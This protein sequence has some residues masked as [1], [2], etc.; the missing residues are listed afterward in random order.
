MK[1]AIVLSG[2]GTRGA[3]ELGVWRALRTLSVDYDLVTG[4]SIGSINGALMATDDFDGCEALWANIKMEDLMADGITI[5]G[6]VTDTME[7]FYNQKQSLRPYLKK[8]LK[9]KGLDNSPFPGFVERYISE[10]RVRA[11]KK[12]FGLVT[13][14]FPSLT[15]FQL[16][17][18]QIPK[19]LLKDFVIASS[20]VF[21]VFPMHRIGEETYLDGCYYDNLPI[22]L[23]VNMGATDIIAVDLHT[24]LQHPNHARRPYVTTIHPTRELGGVLEFDPKRIRENVKTGYRDALKTFGK[25][26]GFTYYFKPESLDHLGNEIERFCYTMARGEALIMET[27]K[28]KL[29]QAGDIYRMFHLFEEYTTNRR[30]TKED[31]FIRA[32]EICGDIYGFDQTKLYDME[33]FC[34]ELTAR[35]E[36]A[37][38]YPDAALFGAEQKPRAVLKRLADLK[39]KSDSVYLTGCLYYASASGVIDFKRQLEVLSYLPHEVAAAL[40][41]HSIRAER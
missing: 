9:N 8:Y 26:K 27:S 24:S 10:E 2:G 28:N 40:F 30:V 4:T 13:V 11:S 19:G 1:R 25:I 35:L 33:E 17:K 23:A 5:A 39:M 29:E 18:D 20:S 21:P 15:P 41:L 14:Q 12:D 3:Y 34:K 6:S 36:P 7:D 32:A 38:H 16:P 31:Y 22:D 37:E